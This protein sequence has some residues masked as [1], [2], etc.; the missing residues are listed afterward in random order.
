MISLVCLRALHAGDNGGADQPSDCDDVR[1]LPEDSGK[2]TKPAP[3]IVNMNIVDVVDIDGVVVVQP[4]KFCNFLFQQQSDVEW[5]FGLA[6][7]IR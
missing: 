7:L 5:K 2:L 3:N 6:K 1:H 4:L